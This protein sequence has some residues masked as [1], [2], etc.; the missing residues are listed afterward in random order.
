MY[1]KDVC[2]SCLVYVSLGLKLL[3]DPYQKRAQKKDLSLVGTPGPMD[4]H[5]GFLELLQKL[6]QGPC[7]PMVESTEGF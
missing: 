7:H 4:A 5:M 3:N 1:Q 2:C 6:T